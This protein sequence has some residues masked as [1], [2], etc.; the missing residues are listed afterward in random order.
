M[1]LTP[2]EYA[3]FSHDLQA[4]AHATGVDYEWSAEEGVL[5]FDLGEGETHAY[6][7]LQLMQ[8]LRPVGQDR[9]RA[10]IEAV[11]DRQLASV[12]GSSRLQDR[13]ASDFAF[14]SPRLRV[15]LYAA[16]AVEAADAEP[17]LVSQKTVPHIVEVLAL[18]TDDRV[19]VSV[20]PEQADGWGKPRD[21]L[22]TL[23]YSNATATAVR[24][25]EL[26]LVYYTSDGPTFDPFGASWVIQELRARPT[27]ALV[28]FPTDR[29]A[30]LVPLNERKPSPKQVETLFLQ[31]IKK[32]RRGPGSVVAHVYWHHDGTYEPLTKR[33]GDQIGIRSDY[34]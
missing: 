4:A 29:T 18:M 25:A 21:A 8:S 28:S 30:F 2:Q 6:G 19:M 17:Y 10:E 15:R 12:R 26:D 5:T 11:L 31:T 20:T 9:W 27:S 34:R 16:S 3:S 7:V 13:M 22:F 23:A 33:S 32:F 1:M 14:V 24:E